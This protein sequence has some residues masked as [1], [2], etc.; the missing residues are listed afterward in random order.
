VHQAR[1]LRCPRKWSARGHAQPL[2]TP[3][4]R[5]ASITCPRLC[6]MAPLPPYRRHSY[7]ARR[8]AH[9]S[10][11]P[12]DVPTQVVSPWAC[13]LRTPSDRFASLTCPRS[14]PMHGVS[15]PLP[16]QPCSPSMCP[17][18]WSAR[19]RCAH[20]SGWSPVG[21]PIVHSLGQVRFTHLP[22]VVP[23]GVSAPPGVRQHVHLHGTGDSVVHPASQLPLLCN[24]LYMRLLQLEPLKPHESM[25]MRQRRSPDTRRRPKTAGGHHQT[26]N[27][28]NTQQHIHW[29]KPR[30]ER[31]DGTPLRALLTPADT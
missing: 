19:R 4:D 18:K 30:P 13:P 12:V 23:N 5:F 6:P 10:G 2:C 22:S 11:Q 3:L 20:V 28:K 31:L 14:C 26:S 15:A 21:V 1:G 25:V 29:K 27:E 7:A 17:C 16:S 24:M 9:A 8:Y